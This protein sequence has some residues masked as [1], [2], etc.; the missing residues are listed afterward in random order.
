MMLGGQE[1]N[2]GPCGK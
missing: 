2:R 1:G